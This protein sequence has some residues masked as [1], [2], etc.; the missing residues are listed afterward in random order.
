[1][2]FVLRH[3]LPTSSQPAGHLPSVGAGGHSPPG[4]EAGAAAVSV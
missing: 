3:L 1:M 2:T 4:F